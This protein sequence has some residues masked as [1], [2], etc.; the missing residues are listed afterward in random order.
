MIKF[1]YKYIQLEEPSS[2]W[3]ILLQN[4][5]VVALMMPMN[6]FDIEMVTNQTVSHLHAL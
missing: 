2:V 4:T 3:I 6:G 5:K 1:F